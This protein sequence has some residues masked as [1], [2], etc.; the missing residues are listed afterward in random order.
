MY[1]Y[2]SHP[3]PLFT[4]TFY[5]LHLDLTRGCSQ[6][7][8]NFRSTQ[9]LFTTYARA[10]PASV[11]EWLRRSIRWMVRMNKNSVG[12]QQRVEMRVLPY[13]GGSLCFSLLWLDRILEPK[14]LLDTCRK[15]ET[16]ERRRNVHVF[17]G[18]SCSENSEKST[19]R[20]CNQCHRS[21][22]PCLESWTSERRGS[23]EFFW[24][25]PPQT[26]KKNL[27]ISPFS[28][29]LRLRPPLFYNG[30]TCCVHSGHHCAKTSLVVTYGPILAPE[31][32]WWWWSGCYR[33]P[34]WSTV[35]GWW[36]SLCRFSMGWKK[37]QMPILN[38]F[39]M[40]IFTSKFIFGL[41][42]C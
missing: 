40:V 20:G 28:L 6:K 8:I 38:E 29:Y 26:S 15:D 30:A 37:R 17:C 24:I 16:K 2:C 18:Q 39:Y 23:D 31:M 27:I 34:C 36:W 9:P 42:F 7:N 35:R 21:K 19:R 41:N 22:T 5:N 4:L 14:H 33:W 3:P 1:F 32:E 13:G 11:F 10:E 12:P 25:P